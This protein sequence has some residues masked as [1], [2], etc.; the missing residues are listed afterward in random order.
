MQTCFLYIYPLDNRDEFSKFAQRFADAYIQ[1]KPGTKHVLYV[2]FV[3]GDPE[4]GD[5]AIFSGIKAEFI[6]VQ[7]GGVDIG[8]AQAALDQID[9]DYLVTGTSRMY[10]YKPNWLKRM[11]EVRKEFGPGLYGAMASYEINS[12]DPSM[13]FP[14]RHIRT[15]F[16]GFEK[17]IWRTRYPYKI[18]NR[19]H[20]YLFESG[21]W[22]QTQWA[23][24]CGM[25]VRMITWDNSYGPEQWHTV[26]G[27]FRHNNQESVLVRD[28]H[29]Q[30]WEEA[31][32]DIKRL[33][34][35]RAWG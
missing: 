23:L 30:L 5:Y 6:Q 28:R 17:E 12:L 27:R 20:A 33:W 25:P 31:D 4:A 26:P 1:H 22:S 18:K 3:N 34:S 10:P 19:E 15:C 29:T 9:C 24:D 14:N 35:K 7:S 2:A 11:V 8:A 21:A 13:P 16:Y 32:P